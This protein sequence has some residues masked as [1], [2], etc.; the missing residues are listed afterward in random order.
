M[1]ANTE[2]LDIQGV[3][4]TLET[5]LS[6]GRQDEAL[7][8][9]VTLLD[10]LR[11]QNNELMLKLG[12]LLRQRAGKRGEK[13]DPKQLALMLEQL[14]DEA[15]DAEVEGE[16]DVS[17]D[18][19]STAETPRKKRKGHGRRRLPP[20]LPREVIE[21][22]LE[23]SEQECAGCGCPMTRI[24]EDTSEV[25]EFRPAQFIVHRHVQGKYACPHCKESVKTAPG[26][27]KV[28]ER[29][30]AGPGMLAH[31]ALSKYEDHIPLTRQHR[32]YLRS[33]VDLAVSTLCDWV[34]RTSD[35]LEPLAKRL[36]E[37]AV[38]SFLVQT[39]ATGLKVLDPRE[40]EN[41][42]KGT[43]WSYVGD[44]KYAVFRYAPTGTGEDGPWT[45]LAGRT[46]YIQADAANVFD[47]LFNGQ[48]AD[49]VEV[50]CWA[51]A[52]RRFFK[53]KDSDPRAAVPLELIRKLYRI[54]RDADEKEL[55][56]TERIA[57]RSRRS[58]K[59]TNQLRRWLLTTAGREPPSS[60][61]AKAV[62][63][64]LNHW[65]ALTRFFEEGRLGLDNN[66]CEQQLRSVALGR[67]NYLFAGSDE[68]AKRAAVIYTI[69]RTCAL[70]DVDP[71]EYLTDVLPHL[72]GDWPQSRIDELL[73]DAWGNN[74]PSADTDP[75]R[76]TEAA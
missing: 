73:P 11:T 13:V 58:K 74:R 38:E 4:E 59:V 60:Q 19:E 12:T 70:N 36:H 40:S 67:R 64:S 54:E 7:D 21:H 6:E 23:D 61:L 51:H 50:G 14:G 32:I 71:H 53:L 76:D 44:R 31:V 24:G 63:Y 42:R 37:K 52:R 26:P 29:G 33:G 15:A 34:A 18:N 68:G 41:I 57:L 45:Y 75:E 72:A 5:F 65:G 8:M 69:M 1:T 62:A 55:N 20:H 17:D 35:L 46:G 16:A 49:A 66:L 30:L 2:N 25:L 39:D 43:I 48:V 10:G 27:D 3:R 22:E 28:I 47:R 9:V 56:P